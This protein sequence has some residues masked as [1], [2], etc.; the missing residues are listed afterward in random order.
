[1]LLQRTVADR[2]L[3]RVFGVND[4]CCTGAL[5]VATGL[6][7]LP[8]GTRVDRWVGLILVVVAVVTLVAAV[9]TLSRRLRRGPHGWALNLAEN[10]NEFIVKFWYRFQ[11]IGRPTVP[12]TGPVIVTSNHV[13][14][15]DPLLLYASAPYR[16]ISFLIAAEYER[17]PIVRF[18]VRSVECIPVRRGTREI[19]ATKQAIRHLEQG[20]ALGIFIEGGIPNP[21]EPVHLKDGVALLALKTGAAVVPAFI[22]GIA[23][24]E[25][26]LRGLFARQH[27]RVRFGPPVD[28]REFRVPDPSRE[29]VRAATRRIYEA[30]L[31]LAPEPQTS[32]SASGCSENSSMAAR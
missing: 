10:L 5:L 25:R 18:I 21:G 15:A 1:A 24:H 17:W 28:L 9:V 2:F 23:Y 26:V 14:P 31:A 16:A 12:R 20:K 6:L 29:T 4:V 8:S 11:R 19:G 27:A 13:G 30:V 3:G 22:S 32:K 7:G